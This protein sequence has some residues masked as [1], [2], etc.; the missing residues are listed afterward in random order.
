VK[1]LTKETLLDLVNENKSLHMSLESTT[2]VCI[3]I[4]T[5]NSKV[6]IRHH[7][8]WM[9]QALASARVRD[10]REPVIVSNSDSGL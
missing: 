3:L 5:H 9:A 4:A 8:D 7:G 2:K 1:S 10:S 6:F